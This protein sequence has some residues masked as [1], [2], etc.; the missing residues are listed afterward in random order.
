MERQMVH[1]AICEM[2]TLVGLGTWDSAAN[3]L[4]MDIKAD[5]T[6]KMNI[7]SVCVYSGVVRSAY[8][9]GDAVE[10]AFLEYAE[11]V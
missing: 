10:D 9:P 4:M 2:E 1:A 7:R 3:K 8:Y 11:N 6:Q 5:F